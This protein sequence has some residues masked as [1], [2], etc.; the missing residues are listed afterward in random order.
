MVGF[1]SRITNFRGCGDAL[2][3]SA[4][5]FLDLGIGS[6]NLFNQWESVP[7]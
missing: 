2:R 4:V 7:K 5:K 1:S 6:L 3:L